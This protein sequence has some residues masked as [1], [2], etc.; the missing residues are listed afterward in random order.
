METRDVLT[1]EEGAQCSSPVIE[2]A[3]AVAGRFA[4]RM[5][6]RGMLGGAALGAAGLAGFAATIGAPAAEAAPINLTTYYSIL[7]TGEAL[8]TTFYAL[9]VQNHRQLGFWGEDL[10]ALQ[11]IAATEEI[12]YEFAKSQGG[13]PATLT[14]S[15][16]HGAATFQNRK[17]YLE[18]MELAETLTSGAL[19][20]WILDMANGNH[21]RL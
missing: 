16:P 21:P 7:A 19:L 17:L 1:A 14:F 20:A 3:P 15:F 4:R 5:S 18:T 6:R 13:S 9:G 10:N 12:H 2:S 11:A 8:F